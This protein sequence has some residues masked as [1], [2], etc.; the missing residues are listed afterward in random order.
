MRAHLVLCLSLVV[1]GCLPLQTYYRDGASLSLLERDQT[2]CEVRA[3]KEAPV[4]TTVIRE[5]PRFI[6]AR[7]VCPTPTTC[8]V[9]PGYFVPGD[10]YTVD[11]NLNLRRKVEQLCMADLGYRRESIPQCPPAVVE[12]APKA[13]TTR[14]PTLTEKSCVI[15][16]KD[17]TIQIVNRQ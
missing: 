5:P 17:G 10:V 11:Q 8:Y 2:A 1:S 6:P 15:R 3:L 7:K 12:A 14:L 16:N 4:A 13:A 9:K